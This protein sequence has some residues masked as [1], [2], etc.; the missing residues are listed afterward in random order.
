M[1]S[2]GFFPALRAL[3]MASIPFPERLSG[4]RPTAVNQVLQEVRKA[5]VRGTSARVARCADNPIRRRRR[6]LS[7]RRA[8]PCATAAPAIPTTR[9]SRPCACAVAEKLNREQG[10][11]YDPDREILITDGAT[12]GVCAALGALV[13]ATRTCL[14]A[15]PD[16]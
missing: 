10:L 1:A 3:A 15:R 13:D 5:P 16:L 9:E 4:L 12:L 14:A 7:R 8:R 2:H 6:T 11:S